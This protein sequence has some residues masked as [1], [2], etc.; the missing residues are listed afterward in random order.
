MISLRNSIAFGA[1]LAATSLQLQAQATAKPGFEVA[2]VK[3]NPG[4]DRRPRSNQPVSPGRLTMQCTTLNF[5]IQTAYGVWANGVSPDPVLVEVSGG[6]NWIHSAFYAILA[7]AGGDQTPAQVH[8]PMLQALLEDRFK[9]RLHRETRQAPIYALTL[10]KGGHKLRPTPEASCDPNSC[11]RPVPGANGRNIT[12]DGLGVNIREFAE[13]FLSRILDRKTVDQ[14]GLTGIFDFHL[15]FTPDE[16]TPLGAARGSALPAEPGGVS[17]FT[18]MEEQLGLSLKSDR[19]PL[20]VLVV[21]S[22][23]RPD[24]N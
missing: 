16:A 17:I 21:D 3:L 9:L 22:V 7:T 15:E 11:G 2:S 24:E 5:A 13:G 20:D 1:M 10:A 18:A 23:Q 4:C 19:G 14:T 8:G 12:L 6:P